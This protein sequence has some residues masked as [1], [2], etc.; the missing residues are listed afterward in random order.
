MARQT[1]CDCKN[2]KAVMN[3][4]DFFVGIY[5]QSGKEFARFDICKTCMN[6]FM[7]KF[8]IDLK[9]KEASNIDYN[10]PSENFPL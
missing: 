1:I 10:I 4:D 9:A 7:R 8:G 3:K 6:D 5:T 2:C